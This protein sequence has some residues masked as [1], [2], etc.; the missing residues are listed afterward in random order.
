MAPDALPIELGFK[1]NL[2]QDFLDLRIYRII[3]QWG[4]VTTIDYALR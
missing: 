2:N 1:S 4:E 3:N